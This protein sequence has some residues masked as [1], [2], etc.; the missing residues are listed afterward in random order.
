[1]DSVLALR[2]SDSA[3]S[4]EKPT[5]IWSGCVS[6]GTVMSSATLCLLPHPANRSPSPSSRPVIHRLP[7]LHFFIS[8]M[9]SCSVIL[10]VR[11][12]L[13]HSLIFRQVLSLCENTPQSSPVPRRY[14][15]FYHSLHPLSVSV[16]GFPQGLH[17]P[18]GCWRHFPR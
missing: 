14:V 3:P 13:C 15:S 10:S 18:A 7:V 17:S 8:A 9:S 16:S 4:W 1:M 6:S 5:T 2:Q 12:P 11:K